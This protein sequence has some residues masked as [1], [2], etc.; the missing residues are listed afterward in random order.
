MIPMQSIS[1]A[2]YLTAQSAQIY[3][4]IMRTFYREYEHMHFQ[5]YEEELLPLLCDSWPELFSLSDEKGLRLYLDQLVYWKNLTPFQDPRR[6]YT[7][8][9]YKNKKF[10]YAMTEAAVEIER[11]TRRLEKMILEPASLSTNYFVRLERALEQI[12]GLCREGNEG[13]VHEWWNALQEDFRALNQNYQDYLREFYSGKSEKLLKSVE[14]VLHKDRFISY[15][16]EFIRQLQHYCDRIGLQLRNLSPE[17]RQT[18]LEMAVK[19]ELAIPRPGAE[20]AQDLKERIRDN[21]YGR[22]A[23]LERWFLPEEN[24]TG[25]EDRMRS[26]ETAMSESARILD[27]TNEIIQKIIQNAALIVQMH[28]WGI[29]RKSDYIRY[30]ELFQNA[31]SLDEAHCLAAHLFGVQQVRHFQL[32]GERETDSISLSTAQENPMIFQLTPHT[33][34]YQPRVDKTGFAGKDLEKAAQRAAHLQ[35]MEEERRLV[36]RYI[37]EGRLVFKQIEDVVPENVRRIFLGWIAQAGMNPEKRGHTEYG[38]AFTLHMG[39]GT[40]LLRCEDGDLRMPCYELE[41]DE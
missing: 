20:N 18:I 27:I 40:C 32:S 41:F 17:N 35:R 16:Q 15:L 22:F 21:I 10:R 19:A 30:I 38:Q 7:I 29:S 14:F 33:R 1:E 28:N 39:E 37:R 36:M 2:A 26:G 4:A 24:G 6:V 11:M 31:V 8:A 5:L 13:K 23:A 9:D 3:R 34:R 12:P 25:E